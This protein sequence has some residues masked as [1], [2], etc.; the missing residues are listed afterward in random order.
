VLDL[1]IRNGWVVDG[2][3]Q[4]R[5][6]ADVGIDGD[7]IVGI[8]SVPAAARE[9]DATGL[10]VA[11]GFIDP[12]S[13]TD[14]T[15]HANR[16]A[17]STI[18]QGVT[19]EVVGNCGITN[20][21]VSDASLEFVEGRLR[22]YGYPGEVTWRSFGEYLDDVG[23]GGT[24]QNLAYFVG[25]STIRAA[26][27]VTGPTPS[28]A[29]AISLMEDLVREA[30][31][32]GALGMSS[33]LEYSLGAFAATRELE[34]LA[35]I[36]GRYG[37]IYASHVRNR[38]SKIL[39]SIDEFLSIMR[40]G[41][42]AGQISHLN[43]RHDTNA[44]D[45]A[46]E[47]AVQKMIDARSRGF[48]VQADTTP[49]RQGIGMMTGILPDWILADGY[50]AAAERMTDPL[51][52]SRLRTDCDRY[53]RFIHKG[54]WERVRLQNSPQ[55][56]ELNGRSFLE[57]ARVR[58]Q[59]VWDSFFDV[60]SAAGRDMGDLIMVGDLFTEEHLAEMVSHPLFSLGV[61]AYTSV[62]HGPLSDITVN[63]L[64]YCG[65]VYYLTHHVRERHTL[66]LEEAV[67]KM[68]GMPAAR[69][70]LHARGSIREGYF[71]DIVVF[72]FDALDSRSTFAE[73]AVYPEGITL[74]TVNGTVVVD[75]GTHTGARAGR[76]LRRRY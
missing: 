2:T 3:G 37:G 33:G 64:P 5:R 63:P 51:V 40:A 35:T 73:P 65:H 74:V 67:R 70:G 44:P 76:V 31:E 25:H 12:H 14:W 53:W 26:A 75:A 11:P 34:R 55:L 66:S 27:G 9:I 58:R 41:N 38:D 56:P 57:I 32:A 28:D 10:V 4:P 54:Q 36:V 21:P 71:A 50:A 8:G 19:T 24:A 43:V 13:H 23:S 62:D 18:R 72:D 45:H 47:R 46:W 15:L 52:R 30:M 20:A 60:L 22:A 7:R 61:D 6:R 1:A 69:F 42:T 16:D 48:D 29:D 39:E 68:S 59:D 17:H 49:F